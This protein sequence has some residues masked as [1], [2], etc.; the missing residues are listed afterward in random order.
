MKVLFF[1]RFKDITGTGEVEV[2]GFK[3]LSDL[4][5]YLFEK[6]PKLRG[7]T[8]AIAVNFEIVHSDVE[9]NDNDEIALLPPI[10]GG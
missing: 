9:L 10:A 6:Y 3:N 7:E 2:E 4:K 8:F 1:G 5:A